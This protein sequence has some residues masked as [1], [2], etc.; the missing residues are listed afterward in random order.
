MYRARVATHTHDQHG[1]GH[2]GT[3]DGEPVGL[4]PRAHPCWRGAHVVSSSRSSNPPGSS[5]PTRGVPPGLRPALRR[6]GLI[7]AGAGRTVGPGPRRAW[8]GA[9]PRWRGADWVTEWMIGRNEGS[10]PLARGGQMGAMKGIY[11]ARLIP[12]GAGRTPR[13]TAES[14]QMTAHPR[15]RGADQISPD[16]ADLAD[17]SSPLARGG[18]T[19]HPR[20]HDLPGLIPAGAGRTSTLPLCTALARAH[21]RW[22][23]ADRRRTRPLMWHLGSSPLARG[24]RPPLNPLIPARRLI[25]AGAGRTRTTPPRTAAKGAHPRWR[26]AD[27]VTVIMLRPSSGSSPLA[28]GGRRSGRRWRPGCGLIPAGAGRTL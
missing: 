10:S 13:P 24:G 12:A 3:G 14:A 23:G 25:P 21:P 22:R 2:G 1:V 18:P 19:H 15:W 9:H 4:V 8:I 28:R 7:P 27:S 16:A 26:G 5:P 6:R 17:G 11:T 20:R